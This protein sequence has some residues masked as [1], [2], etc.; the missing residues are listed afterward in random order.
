MNRV[1]VTGMGIVSA[2]GH[3]TVAFMNSIKEG[4]CGVKKVNDSII[5]EYL[6]AS[7]EDFNLQEQAM[8]YSERNASL[9]KKFLREAKRCPKAMQYTLKAV[10]EAWMQA[11]GEQVESE[12][13][14]CIIAG[15]NL[16]NN[17]QYSEAMSFKERYE[18]LKPSIFLQ[19]MDTSYIGYVSELFN[20]R[21]EGLTVGGT[22]ASGNV[23]IIKACQLIENGIVDAC[24]VV[25]A[26]AELSPM[27][28]QGFM[29]LGGMGGKVLKETPLVASCPFDRRHEGFI[30]GQSGA[31]LFLESEQH[32]KAR[33]KNILAYI[34]G[35]SI[36]LDGNH[37]TNPNQQG[38]ERAM[39]NALEKAHLMPQDIDYINAHGTS[40][41]LG[42]EV[43]L[44][45]IKELFADYIQ[46]IRVNS[47]K[48][49]TGHCLYSAGVV[50]AISTII[51]INNNFLHG[52]LNLVNPIED[53][54]CLC[55]QEMQHTTIKHAISNS[56]A[57]GGIN[58]SIIILAND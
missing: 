58:T 25:G 6:T 44:Q 39:R 45:A 21:G 5:G 57:F 30:Y 56:F 43:E 24:V 34:T 7:I 10:L 51:Q 49:F 9:I 18:Y 17:W 29:Q 2:I 26:C 35:G 54:A 15:N 32:A 41:P 12:K 47:T 1:A 52:N 53:L 31:C 37:L 27:D 33:E 11:E 13:I 8:A 19:W 36:V 38:E 42:D 40:T 22:S 46:D 28:I 55:R 16:S 48:G 4:R 23:G 50:E 3:D 20:I 14:G